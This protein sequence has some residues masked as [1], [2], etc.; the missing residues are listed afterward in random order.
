M[1]SLMSREEKYMKSALQLARRGAGKT[2]PNPMVG[3]IIVKNG[4][5]IGRGFHKL[6]GGHH[7]EINALN[8]CTTNPWGS[9]VY[10]NLEPC[11]HYGKTPPCTNALI[12]AGIKKIF[13]GMQDPNP[14]VSG[15][16]VAQLTQAGIEVHVAILEKECRCLNEAFIKHITTG[17]PFVTLKSALTLDGKTST[18]SGHSKWITSEDSRKLTH[19]LRAETDAVMVGVGTVIADD[20]L[21]TVR[22]YRK[23]SKN[24]LRIIL[25]TSLR[26]PL[27]CRAL[28]P[29]LAPKTIIATSSKMA[30]SKKAGAIRSKGAKI[31]KVSVQR[32]KVDIKKLIET[33]GQM[34]I[35]SILIEGG[36]H[37]NES[38]LDSGIVDKIM[39]F[40]APEIMGGQNSR[41]IVSGKGP[42][43]V[44]DS[45]TV[46]DISIKKVGRD[47]LI[48]GYMKKHS[49][50]TG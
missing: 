5:I 11:C 15:R 38:S 27:A 30:A 21:L 22:L 34:S 32:N 7:A 13:I 4:T 24:P 14:E 44:Y 1:P 35:S 6:C 3:A 39:F 46:H 48:T 10:I 28:K 26:I 36:P 8:N 9:E 16:G 31:V 12:K 18:H 42:E 45:K 25:D 47:F 41:S 37:I 23:T 29:D 43:K 2:S 49:K 33:L 20:P 17:L 19:K 40:Y 50:K